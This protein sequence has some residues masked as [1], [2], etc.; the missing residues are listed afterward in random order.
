MQPLQAAIGITSVL[1]THVRISHLQ[2]KPLLCLAL[3]LLTA[4]LLFYIVMNC[5]T[6]LLQTA[7]GSAEYE[8]W[9]SRHPEKRVAADIQVSFQRLLFVL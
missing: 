3:Y 8:E 4:A 1:L 6:W 9:R 7:T 5:L 2:K